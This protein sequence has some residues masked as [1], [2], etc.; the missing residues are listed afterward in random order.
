MEIGRVLAFG[1]A[2]GLPLWLLVE[3][4]AYR[5]RGWREATRPRREPVVDGAAAPS[6][7]R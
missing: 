1:I 6:R 4:L 5:T 3:E 7:S 2:L